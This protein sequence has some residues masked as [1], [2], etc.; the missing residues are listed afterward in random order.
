MEITAEAVANH[1]LVD[2][3]QRF[4]VGL[5]LTL[6]PVF[7][8]EMGVYPGSGSPHHHCGLSRCQPATAEIDPKRFF[9]A[10]S[11]TRQDLAETRQAAFIHRAQDWAT[12]AG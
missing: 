8:L 10:G 5:V 2:M 6:L 12:L 3:S 1:E 7:I 11:L 4:W 9:L